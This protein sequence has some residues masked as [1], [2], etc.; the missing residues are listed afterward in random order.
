MTVPVKKKWFKRR[1]ADNKAR[2]FGTPWREAY[3]GYFVAASKGFGQ[4]GH[5]AK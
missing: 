4:R 1:A 2:P 3:S 5:Y